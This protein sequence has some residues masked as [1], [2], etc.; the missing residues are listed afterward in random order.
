MILSRRTALQTLGLKDPVTRAD[1][2]SAWRRKVRETH[3]DAGGAGDVA[4]LGRARDKLLAD[5]DVRHSGNNSAGCGKNTSCK[6]CG[7]R[8][9]VPGRFGPL[10]CVA[11]N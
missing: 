6:L 9:T 11:C 2:E 1:I 5:D 3:P 4:T 7:G 8:R 10:A